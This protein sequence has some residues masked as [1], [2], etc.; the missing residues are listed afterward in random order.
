M[1]DPGIYPQVYY[2]LHIPQYLFVGGSNKKQ[3]GV[4]LFQI[5]QN[6]RLFHPQWQPNA[7]GDNLKQRGPTSCTLQKTPFFPLNYGQEENISGHPTERRV[8]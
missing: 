5:S 3:R 4:G 1:T 2:E 6:E 7:L 8:Y